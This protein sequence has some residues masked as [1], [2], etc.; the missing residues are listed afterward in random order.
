M[1][2]PHFVARKTV[3][4]FPLVTVVAKEPALSMNFF[5]DFSQCDV[6]CL[7]ICLLEFLPLQFFSPSNPLLQAGY[8]EDDHD[9]ITKLKVCNIVVQIGVRF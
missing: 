7:G 3:P 1:D 5:A 6:H 9:Y 8:M 4:S 2:F